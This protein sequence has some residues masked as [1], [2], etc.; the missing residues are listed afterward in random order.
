MPDDIYIKETPSGVFFVTI[1]SQ[2]KHSDPLII[3]FLSKN[4]KKNAFYDKYTEN[5]HFKRENT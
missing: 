3:K 4:N 1:F 2:R 5:K